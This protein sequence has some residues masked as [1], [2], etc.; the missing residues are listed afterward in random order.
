MKT[1]R[2][3]FVA[4]LLILASFSAAYAQQQEEPDIDKII[5]DYI[6]NLCKQYD[7][8]EVQIFLIDSTLQTNYPGMLEDFHEL[9]AGGASST[10]LFQAA[11]DKWMDKT[12]KSFE[13]IFTPAQ[14]KKYMKSSA[15]K[16][17]RQRE[18][19]MAERARKD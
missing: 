10:E 14:W 12:D 16:E 18:K 17:M 11:S 6:E 7:L 3:S 8:D 2:Y 15:G 5:N 4:F 19:R 13:K 9:K 1:L